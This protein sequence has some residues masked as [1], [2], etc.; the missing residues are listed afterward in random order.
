MAYVGRRHSSS[1]GRDAR[2]TCARVS[3]KP[4]WALSRARSGSLVDRVVQDRAVPQAKPCLKLGPSGPGPSGPTSESLPK[5][6]CPVRVDRTERSGRR[7]S[8][9]TSRPGAR[10]CSF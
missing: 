5:F 4:E 6:P 2:E 10:A 8:A 1:C 3:F 9:P 7:A